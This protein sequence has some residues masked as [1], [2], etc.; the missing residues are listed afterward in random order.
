VIKIFKR[1]FKRGLVTADLEEAE[2]ESIVHLKV[3]SEPRKRLRESYEKEAVANSR[4]GLGTIE[5]DKYADER[6]K[7]TLEEVKQLAIDYYSE[8]TKKK[9]RAI[10]D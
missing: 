1:N 5:F 4:N 6:I 7:E 3:N 2:D 8:K 9:L 10:W